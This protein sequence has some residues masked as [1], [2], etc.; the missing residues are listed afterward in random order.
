[1]LWWSSYKLPNTWKTHLHGDREIID[2]TTLSTVIPS[3][4]EEEEVK[5]GEGK[6]GSAKDLWRD[7]T[8]VWEEESPIG[9][10]EKLGRK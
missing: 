6:I 8:E 9:M 10:V 2:S 1:M 7:Q 3:I 5:V 4:E